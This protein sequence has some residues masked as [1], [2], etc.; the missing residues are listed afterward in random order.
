M[1]AV[2]GLNGSLIWEDNEASR[3]TSNDVFQE[4]L[5]HQQVQNVL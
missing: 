3:M 4:I 5:I 2:V 1:M